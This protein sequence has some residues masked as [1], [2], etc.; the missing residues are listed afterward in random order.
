MPVLK[1]WH[2]LIFYVLGCILF[3]LIKKG[4]VHMNI[5]RILSIVLTIV[6]LIS[7]CACGKNID[8]PPHDTPTTTPSTTTPETPENPEV[9]IKN[10]GF[11]EFDNE[12]IA[13]LENDMNYNDNL[14]FHHYRTSMLLF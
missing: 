10:V 8:T 14:W 6:L 9:P 1:D 7:L 12:L 13:F 4:D 2:F 5:K 3:S 11:S